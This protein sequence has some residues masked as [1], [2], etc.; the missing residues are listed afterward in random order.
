MRHLYYSLNQIVLVFFA[1]TLLISCGS[2][3]DILYFQHSKDLSDT[4]YDPVVFEHNTVI[5]PYDNLFIT[6]SATH[7]E[8]VIAFNLNQVNQGTNLTAVAVDVQGYL[9]DQSGNINFPLIG[10]IKVAGLTKTEVIRLLQKEISEYVEDQIIV[11][12]RILN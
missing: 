9:V 5:M 10:E 8:S 6:V 4:Q 3:R 11:N 2:Q 7:P 1:F 12:I